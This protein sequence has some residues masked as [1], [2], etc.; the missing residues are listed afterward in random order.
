M[1]LKKREDDSYEEIHH[2]PEFSRVPT[3]KA[4]MSAEYKDVKNWLPERHRQKKGEKKTYYCKICILE[5]SSE[6]TMINHL[7]GVKHVKRQSEWEGEGPGIVQIPNPRPS[8][9]KVPVRLHQKI[10]ECQD[11]IVG[12]NWIVEILPVSDPEMEPHYRCGLC[13][14]QGIANGMFAHLTGRTH[15]KNFFEKIYKCDMDLSQEKLLKLATKHAENEDKLD[16]KIE[17]RKS[18]DDYPWPVGKAPWSV[19]RGGSGVPP[20]RAPENFGKNNASREQER[21][22]VDGGGKGVKNGLT[23]L[24]LSTLGPATDKREALQMVSLADKMLQYAMDFQSSEITPPEK[25]LIK[26]T[27]S[28]LFSKILES[29]EDTETNGRPRKR[30]YSSISPQ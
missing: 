9:V 20:D 2:Q 17:T 15:R 16:K 1:S 25:R 27:V 4:D 11:P 6:D 21:E 12:L 28:S 19:E 7:N 13:G 24:S 18:D 29:R 10:R 23:S 14:N 30:T 8:R 22:R 3:S 26:L 5:L